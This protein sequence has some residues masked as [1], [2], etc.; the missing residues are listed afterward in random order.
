MSSTNAPSPG[1]LYFRSV[2]SS[3]VFAPPEIAEENDRIY[4][5]ITESKTW[6]EFRSRMPPQE[7]A[8]LTANSF[9]S[10]PEEIA[11]GPEVAPPS[12]EEEFS[13]ECIPGFCDGDYPRW[14]AGE[15]Q[16]YV[17]R[18]ILQAFGK[19]EYT[20]LN[21]PCWR[22]DESRREEVL[23]ALRAEGHELVERD[24]LEFY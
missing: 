11:E 9:S 21:G 4:R 19:R 22:I 23:A 5:A 7:Y 3:L 16:R 12:D 8:A 20:M 18:D 13:S 1:I 10:D 2:G 17:S 14:I 6:G 24:D 15:Q